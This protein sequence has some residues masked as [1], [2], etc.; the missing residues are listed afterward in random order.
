MIIGDDDA[1]RINNNSRPQRIRHALTRRAVTIVVEA[2]QLAKNR[3]IKRTTLPLRLLALN[4][5]GVDINDCW[6]CAL[7]QWRK[8]HGDLLFITRNKALIGERCLNA[9]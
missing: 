6:C 7:H 1:C 5:F 2:K 4:G 3:I 9:Q 8:G